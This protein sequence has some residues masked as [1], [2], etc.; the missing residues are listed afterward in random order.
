LKAARASSIATSDASVALH[1]GK[2]ILQP[3]TQL[4]DVGAGCLRSPAFLSD[5]AQVSPLGRFGFPRTLFC[6][7]PGLFQQGT[8]AID[9]S[10]EIGFPILTMS[11]V[12]THFA[13]G[14]VLNLSISQLLGGH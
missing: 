10:N 2:R 6:I 7:D 9:L 3:M 12:V 5:V 4:I 8:Q 13:V 14:P 1:H 11:L